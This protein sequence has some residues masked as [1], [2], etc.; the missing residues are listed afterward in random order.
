MED[1][2]HNR[3]LALEQAFNKSDYILIMDADDYLS[4]NIKVAFKN[5]KADAYMLKMTRGGIEYFCR[6]IIRSNL[7]WKWEGVLH[8]SLSCDV[9]IHEEIFKKDCLINS[10]TDGS[11]GKNPDK[12]KDD[13]NILEKALL[14]EPNNTRYQFYL[15]RSYFD[16][17]LFDNALES[18]Q[19]RVLMGGW[20]EEVYYS[21]LEIGRCYENLQTD[22]IKTI[23]AYIKSFNFR[24]QRLEGLYEAMRLCREN[25]LFNLGY[26][27]GSQLDNFDI[28]KDDV[29]FVGNSIYEWRLM[30]ELSICAIGAGYFEKAK[31]LLSYLL[32]SPLTPVE[33]HE[34]LKANLSLAQNHL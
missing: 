1:F 18:Y 30:D 4:C 9:A 8:E 3:N 31:D 11:R 12:Y 6:K 17:E 34:R 7:P 29:L 13:A 2:S 21:L 5:L 24:R 27:L 26:N 14:K 22:I 10:T 25:Q 32:T 33:H 23:D 28:P 16:A 19:K 20:H 15:A